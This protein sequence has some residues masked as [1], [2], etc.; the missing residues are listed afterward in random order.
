MLIE[1]S[2]KEIFSKYFKKYPPDISEHTFTNLFIW[3]KTRPIEF[4]EIGDSLL[5]ITLYANGCTIFG[6]PIGPLTI[7]K[8]IAHMET[9]GES[10]LIGIERVPIAPEIA[11]FETIEDRD[12]F[13][14]VYRQ[15]D[16]A[17]L[18]GRKYHNKRNLIAQCLSEY[19]CAYEEISAANLNE[20][21]AMMERWCK[22]RQCGNNLGLCLEYEAIKE[23]LD[24]YGEL[25]VVGT[26]IRISGKIGAF[27]IGEALN[28]C[29]AVIHFEKAMPEF[30]G[31]YQLINQWF[32]I[33]ALPRFE[34]V[35]REQ[36]M[37]IE[38]LRKA[39]ES[40]YPDH[41]VKKYSSYATGI[42]PVADSLPQCGK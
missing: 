9:K 34:F 18:A 22:A 11:G 15:S 20:V 4:F 30:K 29:T 25:D 38:G 33:R 14:Y 17:E 41:F 28:P 2:H 6:P 7:E 35:N 1:L 27:S 26:A 36:D 24:N 10:P 16:L 40:Y 5:L 31:L 39:K 32:C 13:D 42:K 12:N 3:R 8:A 21:K 37:G 19:D 23:L